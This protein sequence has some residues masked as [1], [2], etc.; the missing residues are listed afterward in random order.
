M[1]APDAAK[2]GIRDM[3]ASAFAQFRWVVAGSALMTGIAM[4]VYPGGTAFDRTTRG[5]SLSRNFLSDLGS[6]TTTS[7]QS[8][9]IGALLFA[10]GLV[11]LT[12]A[13]ARCLWAFLQL[14][15]TDRVAVLL[16]RAAL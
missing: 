15:S 4:L 1:G 3:R 11:A 12:F 6:T 8:N 9:L 14:Y 5:Y 10:A 13:I 16:T 2:R 7:G